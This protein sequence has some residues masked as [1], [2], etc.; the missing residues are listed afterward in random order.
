MTSRN[1]EDTGTVSHSDLSV[2]CVLP[3][4]GQPRHAKRID[5][6]K[7]NGFSVNALTFERDYHK[8][9]VPDCDVFSLGRISKGQYAKRILTLA[10][11]IPVLRRKTRHADVIYVFGLDLALLAMVANSFRGKPVVLEVGDIRPIQVKQGLIGAA[12]RFISRKVYRHCEL[13]VVTADEFV[14]GY[15]NPAPPEPTPHLVIENK[16]EPGFYPTQD[17]LD[18]SQSPHPASEALSTKNDSTSSSTVA[19][20]GV[21]RIGY[22]GLLRSKW[23]FETLEKYAASNPHTVEII[24]A[25]AVQEGHEAFASMIALPNVNYLGPYRSPDDLPQLYLQVDLVWACYPEPEPPNAPDNAAWA[26]AQ[27]VCRSNRFYES[28]YFKVPVISMLHSS[29]GKIVKEYNLGPVLPSHDYNAIAAE[30][31]DVTQQKLD[32]WTTNISNLPMSIYSFTNEAELLG[33]AIRQCV[34]DPI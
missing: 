14:S 11:V 6:L 32:T 19:A 10:R 18:A 33:Q 12:M 5:M 16:L 31:G 13:L 4:I 29:D 15:Y 34:N 25:G 27:A 17:R 26:W 20:S 22:F 23:S 2:C 9:R 8:G 28:C 3:T 24:V 1:Q 7:S 21:T 30:L